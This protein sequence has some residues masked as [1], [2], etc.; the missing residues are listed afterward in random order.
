[1]QSRKTLVALIA[2]V[3]L[4][5][6]GAGLFALNS[7]DGEGDA[8][9]EI[10]LSPSEGVSGTRS[11]VRITGAEPNSP[12]T[13]TLNNTSKT[14]QTDANGSASFEHM[15][16]GLDGDRILVEAFDRVNLSLGTATFTILAPSSTTTTTTTSTTTTI[17]DP[18]G[19]HNVTVTINPASGISGTNAQITVA[20]AA[21]EPV[22]LTI[23]GNA[24]TSGQTDANGNFTYTHQFTGNDGDVITVEAA[25]G[26]G[27]RTGSGSADFTITPTNVAPSVSVNPMSGPSATPATITVKGDPNQPVTLKIGGQAQNS[28]MTDANGSYTYN[29]VFQ[30]PAG[31]VTIEA[32]VG[33]A[34]TGQQT[35]TTSFEITASPISGGPW[36]FVSMFGVDSDD[37]QHAGPIGMPEMADL[38]VQEGSIT[39]EGPSPFVTVSGDLADDG[40]FSITGSG[41]VAGFSDVGVLFE[42]TVTVDGLT[43]LYTMGT[44]GE[45]PTGTPIVYSVESVGVLPPAPDLA[46]F[47]DDLS[48][49]LQSGDVDGPLSQLHPAVFDRYGSDTCAAYLE[50]IA[51]PD[52]SLAFVRV[53][54]IVP[55]EYPTDGL[56]TPI[57][58]AYNVEVE[59]TVAGE[60]SLTPGNVVSTPNGTILWFTDCGDPV[61]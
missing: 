28:G 58:Y 31:D 12:V 18:A 27:S 37:A 17:P 59:V 61:G 43:G 42:G 38:S 9:A 57:G 6:L 26:S 39:I 13:F 36:I 3:L 41:T 11:T 30:G 48:A 1:M 16:T 60:A 55:Y 40:T 10:T 51:N 4:V 54:D 19:P 29:Y 22:T 8:E 56:T 21:N 35:A 45:L 32:T 53:I 23:G 15:F 14:V 49:D 7:G 20:S 24:V 46:G 50:E 47:Y 33:G 25:V 2:V 5:V 52:A 44:G 34:G